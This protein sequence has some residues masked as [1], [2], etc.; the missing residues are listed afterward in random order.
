M[1]LLPSALA[2]TAM[3]AFAACSAQKTAVTASNGDASV[4]TAAGGKSVTVTTREGTTSL[5]ERVD[6]SKL[7]AP[8][9]PG[10]SAGQQAMLQTGS[11]TIAQFK[12]ADGFDKVYAYYKQ[13]LPADSEKT[14]AVTA[15][16][17]I[18]AFQIGSDASGDQI[19][20]QVSSDK[21]GETSILIA[22]VTAPPAAA[23]PESS[24]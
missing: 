3:V 7:G 13:H 15:N 10:A 16:G 23:S 22:R 6:P 24:D 4:T 17:S 11:S 14:K 9:Y 19:T 2:L 8:V 12:T 1:R 21:S 5:G 20:V 18:A